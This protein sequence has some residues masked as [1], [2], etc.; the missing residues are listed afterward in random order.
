MVIFCGSD[1]D[2][3]DDGGDGDLAPGPSTLVLTNFSMSATLS[4]AQNIC[5][6]SK[7][8]CISKISFVR[9]VCLIVCVC[10]CVCLFVSFSFFNFLYKPTIMVITCMTH[11][12]T[13]K[14]H[15]SS[16]ATD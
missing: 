10:V 8:S 3:D 11:M 1:D 14:P 9:C 16:T 7:L 2:D 5:S 13:V 15:I 6:L 12:Y 4:S